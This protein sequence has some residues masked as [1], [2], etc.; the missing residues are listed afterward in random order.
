MH[1]QEPAPPALRGL[2][3]RHHDVVCHEDLRVANMTR[4]A[5]GTEEVP[6]RNVAQ[7]AGLNRSI[8]DAG[9]GVFLSIL[10]AK[11]ESAGRTVIAVNPRNTSRT[12][13][14]CGHC[15]A[16]NRVTQAVFRCQRCGLDAHADLVG[17]VNVLRAGLARR[18]AAA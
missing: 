5:R 15:A 16:E 6:G 14:S 4:S 7:K 2:L 18:E 17:A 9:W 11:A 12:C 8:L 3:V 10:T 1:D 13:P